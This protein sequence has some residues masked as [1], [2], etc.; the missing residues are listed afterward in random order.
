MP[1]LAAQFEVNPRQDLAWKRVLLAGAAG[2]FGW[3]HD[4]RE[5]ADV[6][7]FALVDRG[8]Q[9]EGIIE[10]AFYS[11]CVDDL[12]IRADEVE[13]LWFNEYEAIADLEAELEP[14]P[15]SDLLGPTVTIRLGM[16][17]RGHRVLDSV[18]N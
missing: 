8:F 2:F 9:G 17:Y 5:K 6:A 7:L 18:V 15:F 4:N 16:D 13:E 10:D 12:F 1:K 3:N 14:A 11:L